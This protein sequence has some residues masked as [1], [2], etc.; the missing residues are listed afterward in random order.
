MDPDTHNHAGIVASGSAAP[1]TP[2]VT[3]AELNKLVSENGGQMSNPLKP[4]V[5]IYF[6]GGL[7]LFVGTLDSQDKLEAAYA[8][9][10]KE[11]EALRIAL[12]RAK[13]RKSW[14][15][16]ERRRF[17]D[18]LASL[19][20][21][22]LSLSKRANHAVA[23]SDASK[24]L[25]LSYVVEFV[26]NNG[27][28]GSVNKNT[29]LESYSANGRLIFLGVVRRDEPDQLVPVSL[30]W[31]DTI[32]KARTTDGDTQSSDDSESDDDA[33][34]VNND[35]MV[36]NDFTCVP[37]DDFDPATWTHDS[38]LCK[39]GCGKMRWQGIRKLSVHCAQR[40]AQHYGGNG[41]GSVRHMAK[42]R[43]DG[44]ISQH[45]FDEY[46]ARVLGEFNKAKKSRIHR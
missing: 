15:E 11:L 39:N 32:M 36:N 19:E 34:V 37:L 28:I 2:P 14:L 16:A 25:P 45:D 30:P 18:E 1:P 4:D 44:A 3:V 23:P 7:P 9:V 26:K 31:H 29:C 20:V 35:A 13:I 46:E 41:D 21:A 6:Q 22:L 10:L 24:E 27:G 5:Y 40:N 12:R 42:L 8:S 17:P 33:A 38:Q 43:D